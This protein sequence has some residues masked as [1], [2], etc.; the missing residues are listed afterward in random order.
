M[1]A[2]QYFG[3]LVAFSGWGCGRLTEVQPNTDGGTLTSDYVL[4]FTQLP[5]QGV[6][7]GNMKTIVFSLNLHDRLTYYGQ[8]PPPSDGWTPPNLT[9]GYVL[10]VQCVP[11]GLANILNQQKSMKL[12]APGD[13][14]RLDY[15][16]IEMTM[17]MFADYPTDGGDPRIV[18]E[19]DSVCF[20][21][22]SPSGDWQWDLSRHTLS[23]NPTD[24]TFHARLAMP[25]SLI[26]GLEIVFG[27]GDSVRVR[28][29]V[30]ATAALP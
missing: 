9:T 16:D 23:W 15:V 7:S 14:A 8:A 2:L 17:P 12:P 13:A 5:D 19:Q 25:H 18:P 3:I 11:G 30:V 20:G 22:R 24:H 21:Y 1:N 26:D 27:V 29:V 4:D 28:K 6:M 10:G